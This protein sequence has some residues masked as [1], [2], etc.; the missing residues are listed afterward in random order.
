VTKDRVFLGV[1]DHTITCLGAKKGKKR[2]R[3]HMAGNPAAPLQIYKDLVLAGSKDNLVY[4]IKQHKGYLAWS[5]DTGSRILTATA[6]R[7][8]VAASSPL[9]GTLLVLMD[10]RDGAVVA[11]EAL[12]GSDRISA[13]SPHFAGQTLIS[14]TQP[15][16]GG[17]GWLTG[18]SIDVVEIDTGPV[19][20][21]PPT[22]TP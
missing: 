16:A 22:S 8:H 14:A 11:R 19:I 2:Y 20:V 18:Y 17:E 5:A 9:Y 12:P 21:P 3:A 6:T 4:A 13:G 10:L 15:L 1:A 7:G